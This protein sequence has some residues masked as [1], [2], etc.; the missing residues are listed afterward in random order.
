MKKFLS[1]LMMITVAL[2]V[3]A[4][5]YT[6][7][8]L[9]LVNGV[10]TEQTA[11]ITVTEHEGVYDL[12][13]KNFVLMN[14][15][16][17]MPVGNVE[18]TNITPETSGDAIFLRASQDITIAEGDLEDALLWMGPSLGELP[19]E[20][21]AVV[22]GDKLRALINL[23]LMDMMGQLIDVKFGDE[24]VTGKNYHVPIGNFEEWHTAS[25]SFMEPNAWH[26]FETAT[27]TFAPLAGHHLEKSGKGRNESVCARIYATSIFGIVANGTMTT[28]RMNAGSMV[29]ADVK[30][31]AYIDVSKTET[32][33]NGDPYHV[34]LCHR[35]DS[36]VMYVQFHQGTAIAEHPYAT[37]S[38]VITDGTYYQDPEDKTY[39]N[40]VAKA[41]DNKIAVTGN[42]WQ[43]IAIPF[44]Y[45]DNNVEPKAI[46]ITISTNADPGQGSENDEVLIDDL[47]LVYNS[48]LSSLNV[49]GFSPDKFDYVVAEEMSVEELAPVAD[50]QGSYV[51]TTLEETEEGKCAVVKVFA[52]DLRAS[53]TYT[54]RFGKGGDQPTAISPATVVNNATP[55]HFLYDLQGRKMGDACNKG[56]YVRDGRKVVIK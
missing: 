19:V 55:S 26:S 49:E 56:V 6:D 50:G 54:I 31:N 36:L 51:L 39:T 53:S 7:R 23:D 42:E 1:L 47:T 28:G 5:D 21:T 40:V 8:I 45:T 38:A 27:G 46:L 43:R 16:Q 12:N 35:P 22:E 14:G 15:D 24:L 17:P 48:R 2:T 33:G 29:A 25:E 52:E 11:T 37:V 34:A 44:V 32:D 4:T 9:V 10:G 3:K 13:L 18:L 20:V 30:N 41:A